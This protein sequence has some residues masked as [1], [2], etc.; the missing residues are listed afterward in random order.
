M[1]LTASFQNFSLSSLGI[2]APS[3]GVEPNYGANYYLYTLIIQ[4]RLSNN[5]T[6]IRCGYALADGVVYTD[7]AFVLRVFGKIL[8]DS[9]RLTLGAIYYE[10]SRHQIGG[11]IKGL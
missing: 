3:I 5:Y 9:C 4:G 2:L 7:E 11:N 10:Q 8:H 1:Y 6:R